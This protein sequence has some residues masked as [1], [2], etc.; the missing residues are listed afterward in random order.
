M[1]LPS[2]A[3]PV[4]R[5]ARIKKDEQKQSADVKPSCLVQICTPFGCWCIV[6]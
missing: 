1:L 2:Q 4:D 5:K 6:P 3:E